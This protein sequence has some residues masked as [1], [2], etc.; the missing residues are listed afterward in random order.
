MPDAAGRRGRDI[1]IF[2]FT[3]A[4]V[5]PLIEQACSRMA[6]VRALVF[7][8]EGAPPPESMPNATS[9]PPL[10]PHRALLLTTVSR[11]LERARLQEV[12][13]GISELEIQ[14]LAYF[15]QVLGAQL[16][17]RF[18]RGTYGPYAPAMS[19]TLD[20]LEGHH[21]TG[22]GDRSSRVTEFAPINPLPASVRRAEQVLAGQPA[23]LHRLEL[24]LDLVAGFETPYSLE[25]LATVHF[26][27]GHEPETADPEVLAERVAGWSLRKA[28]M[29]TARHVAVAA[30]RL[31]ERR[32]LPG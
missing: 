18:V 23:E 4:K 32:L 6:N 10:T 2:H 13:E 7:P 29:F 21:L 1:W 11:Y 24:L 31:A 25:L 26:A 28:R 9:R 20:A 5:R 17:L 14:K 16:R 19:R 22:I 30:G 3:H 15:L 12:R 27:A 8:P